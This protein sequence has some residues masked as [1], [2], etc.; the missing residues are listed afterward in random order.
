MRIL[1]KEMI[2]V[3][4]KLTITT[5]FLQIHNKLLGSLHSIFLI[6][7]ELS[8]NWYAADIKI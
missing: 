3:L 1:K 7:P 2:R 8:E 5:N 6:K 4:S